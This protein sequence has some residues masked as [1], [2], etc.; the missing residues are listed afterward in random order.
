MYART[1]HTFGSGECKVQFATYTIVTH[2][3]RN[4]VSSDVIMKVVHL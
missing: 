3:P 2:A 1:N 4:K